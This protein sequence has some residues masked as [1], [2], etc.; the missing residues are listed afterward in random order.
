[1]KNALIKT[2]SAAALFF[3][4]ALA[5]SV[6]LAARV[7]SVKVHSRSMDKEV[8]CRV[9]L[10]DSYCESVEMPVVYLLH[11]YGGDAAG[12]VSKYNTEE[13]AD[14]YSIIIVATDGGHSSWYWDSP[15]DSSMK[16]ETFVAGELIEYIDSSYSTIEDRKARAITGYSMGGHGA[17]YLSIRHQDVYGAACSMSGGVDIRPFPER[18][19]MAK[20]LGTIEENPE[21]WDE[22]T[23]MGQLDLLEPNSLRIAFD[24]GVDDFF[25]E[26]NNALHK[27]LLE[28]KIPHRYTT[29][30]GA[31]T[32]KY[33]HDALQYHMLFF[34]RFFAES[35]Y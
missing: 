10:P 11:G 23:V 4:F 28:R 2:L 7:D 35:N 34:D 12:W 18:W 9:I 14:R 3:A 33:W 13:L 20:R 19:D 32:G 16:Y 26:V 8:E 15:V 27:E 24:C 25:F 17:L 30:P 31:H 21:Y 6:L 22:Y 5:P 1:M 29:A